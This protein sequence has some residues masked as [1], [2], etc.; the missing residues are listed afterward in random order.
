MPTPDLTQGPSRE[1]F[2]AM[3]RRQTIAWHV[4]Y[5]ALLLTALVVAFV[6]GASGQSIP[7]ASGAWV[8]AGH[9]ELLG[10]SVR[11]PFVAVLIALAVVY[12]AFGAPALAGG[13]TGRALVHLVLSW[14]LVLAGMVM[15]PE[16]PLWLFFWILFP[17]LWAML[18]T[19]AAIIGTVLAVLGFGLVQYRNE[20]FAA[21]SLTGIVSSGIFSLGLS[22]VIGLFI[23]R[24]V[25]E[26][27]VRAETIDELHATRSQLA[28]AERDRGIGEERERLSREIHDTLAQGFTSV[29]ALTRAAEAALVRGDVDTAR[30]RLTLVEQTAAENLDEARLIVAE[31]SPGHLQSRTLVEAL[32]RLTHTVS[33]RGDLPVQLTVVGEPVAL[34]GVTEVILLRT[35][36]EALSNVRRHSDAGRVDLELRFDG[37]AVR[38][39]VI[40]DGKGFDADDAWGFGLD[41][42]RARVAEVDG[43]FEITSALGQ[44]TKLRVEVPR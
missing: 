41:G 22:V 42:L 40:D 34:G 20:G 16:T 9:L 38:L 35:A 37:D 39:D 17:H 32:E 18:S 6:Q 23:V 10:S 29:L 28:A 44:G 24:L 2:S 31:L 8:G 19:R 33:E 27:E 11:T 12:V 5:A 30:A 21:A 14:G 1:A 13:S 43:S 4:V 36:Q 15:V 3:W 25:H 26:A 7:A